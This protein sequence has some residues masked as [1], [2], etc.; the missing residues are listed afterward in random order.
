MADSLGDSA[1]AVSNAFNDGID[2]TDLKRRFEGCLLG[3]AVCDAVG[4]AVE[5]MPPGT[6]PP[7]EEDIFERFSEYPNPHKLK[8]GQWTDDTSM[9]LCMAKS[10]LDLQELD[11]ADLIKNFR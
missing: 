6:F 4:A 7:V 8:P 11:P 1:D 9:A 10:L 5:F 2:E 3:L